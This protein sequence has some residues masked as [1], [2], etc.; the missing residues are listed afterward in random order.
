M[1]ENQLLLEQRWQHHREPALLAA[2]GGAIDTISFITLFWPVYR[3]RHGKPGGGRCST[4]HQQRR[5]FIQTARHSCFFMLAVA[6]VTLVIKRRKKLSRHAS[7]AACS[8]SRSCCYCFFGLLGLLWQPFVGADSATALITGMAG[9][10]AMGVRNATT[11]LLLPTTSPSTMM[12]GNVTQLTI[13]VV[14]W[15][16]APN[17]E[18]R[19]K[20]KKIGGFGARFFCW[21]QGSERW[22]TSR[23]AFTRYLFRWYWW[24]SSPGA[25]SAPRGI[26][27]TLKVF[28]RGS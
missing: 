8:S 10:M 1:A 20:I 2:S 28:L 5:Y 14:N 18:N 6:L 24:P 22:A 17:R 25:N 3:P 11:R 12:T 21:A 13:D 9:V 15:C 19:A 16:R 23:R 26:S 4:G 27:A 7:L